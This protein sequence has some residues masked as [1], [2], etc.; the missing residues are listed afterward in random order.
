MG[1]T[2]VWSRVWCRRGLLLREKWC[3]LNQTITPSGLWELW[4]F[5][6]CDPPIPL[7][8]GARVLAT[9]DQSCFW[10]VSWSGFRQI[11]NFGSGKSVRTKSWSVFVAAPT[12]AVDF[13]PKW[14]DECARGKGLRCYR[15]NSGV[16]C[17]RVCG[18]FAAVKWSQLSWSQLLHKTRQNMETF[19]SPKTKVIV[20]CISTFTL[21]ATP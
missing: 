15:V 19:R 8:R 16:V 12:G 3:I 18:Q 6:I 1:L 17:V 20:S 5:W 11:L 2:G 4:F 14:G 13:W 21:S 7:C 9:D 10:S